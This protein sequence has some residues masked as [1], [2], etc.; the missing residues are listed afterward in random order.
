M[1]VRSTVTGY[2]LTEGKIYDVKWEYDTVY[3]L[4]CDTGTY[5][6][7]KGFFE[8]VP[9][10]KK[11]EDMDC[12]EL[13]PYCPYIQDGIHHSPGMLCEGSYCQQAYDRYM[14]GFECS[15]D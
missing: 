12:D 1:K 5:C 15:T 6:R 14:E 2:D 10:P 7:P 13:Q 9:E 8:V 3:E 11:L 4:R